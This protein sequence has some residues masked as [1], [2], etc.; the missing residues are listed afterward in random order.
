MKKGIRIVIFAVITALWLGRVYDVLRWKDTHGDYLSSVTQLKET[1]DVT[2]DVVFVGSSHV[3]AGCYPAYF[4]EDAG[5]A[6]FNTA[7]SGMDR[8]SCYYY[9]KYLFRSQHPKLVVIDM[10]CLTF[11]VH[12]YQ[13]NI[14]RNYLSLPLNRDSLAQVSA[15][16][17]KDETVSE[18]LAD[19]LVRWP[20]IHTR[21]RELQR[22]DFI[23]DEANHLGKGEYLNWENLQQA[24][25]QE[26]GDFAP[27]QLSE[28]QLKWLEDVSKLCRENGAEPLFMVL[29]FET[30]RDDQGRMDAAARYAQEQGIPFFDFNRLS[31]ECGIDPDTDYFDNN[32][33]NALGAKKIALFFEEY[34]AENYEFP[35]HRGDA[36]YSSWDDDLRYYYQRKYGDALKKETD[37]DNFVDLLLQT[38][39]MTAVISLEGEFDA[40]EYTALQRLGIDPALC[41]GGGKWLWSEGQLTLLNAN[42][43]ATPEY[44]KDLDEYSSLLVRYVGDYSANNVLIDRRDY[45]NKG[46]ALAIVVYDSLLHNIL[47]GREFGRDNSGN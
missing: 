46:K 15:Y 39:D 14:Y 45:S 35:D 4:W 44:T 18:D 13:G 17:E 27:V 47:I 19:Y 36:A 6:A 11:D 31:G 30:L 33:L 41:P 25:K 8:D 7:I 38:K 1:G 40:E 29:P 10:F 37:L 43:P 16:A 34:F 32:H 26:P 9:L 42:D 3:Y 20:I 5:I 12:E 28:D 2:P 24:K 22:P 23:P 21:Y